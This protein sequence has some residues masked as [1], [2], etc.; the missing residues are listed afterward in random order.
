M[1]YEV[2]GVSAQSMPDIGTPARALRI[3]AALALGVI[4]LLGQGVLPLLLGSLEVE[5][6]L[7][8]SGIG[9]AACA[10]ALAITLSCSLSGLFLKPL[11]LRLIALLGL[12]A[13]A[14]CNIAVVW[15]KDQTGIVVARAA[16]GF[17][18]GVL[19]WIALGMIARTTMTELWGAALN[20]M[21]IVGSVIVAA[22]CTK[23]VIP[24]F[25][26]NG[27]FVVVAAISVSSTALIPF[28]PERY[29]EL[30]VF[31]A[32]GGVPPLRGWLALLGT[33]LYTAAGMGVFIY[34]L[35]LARFVGLGDAVAD[36][37]VT[38]ILLGELGG[39]A[40][41][42]LVAGRIGYFVALAL[43]ALAYLGIWPIYAVRPGAWIFIVA[44]AITGFITF[45]SI[46][47][48]FPLAVEADRS[49]RAALQSGPAQ[50]LGTAVGPLLSA[51]TVAHYGVGGILYLSVALLVAGMGIITALRFTPGHRSLGT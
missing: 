35:P 16:A 22:A 12:L 37:A 47:F 36:T 43:S 10:E 34:L 20:T 9:L 50:M 46:P 32:N 23:Y 21:S 49:R 5:H 18:E 48:L 39:G 38:A 1:T 41:A 45:F 26:I 27:G 7:S 2:A 31:D 15:T 24:R 11:R 14:V 17:F 25:G 33:M 29:A 13:L 3:L 30:Q 28:V 42:M 51:W 6:R 19:F 4:V 8:A 40:L 44:S